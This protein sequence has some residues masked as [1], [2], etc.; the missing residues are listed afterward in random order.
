MTYQK[1]LELNYRFMTQL[2]HTRAKLGYKNVTQIWSVTCLF[3][4]VILC[5]GT[6]DM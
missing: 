5:N 1:W 2:D 6:C 4:Y 3:Q